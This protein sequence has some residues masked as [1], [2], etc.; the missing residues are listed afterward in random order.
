[1]SQIDGEVQIQR[2]EK[3]LFS[4]DTL[5]IQGALKNLTTKY[6]AFFPFYIQDL[7]RLAMLNDSLQ[8]EKEIKAFIYNKDIRSVYDTSQLHFKSLDWLEKDLSQ[9]FKYY[10][11]YVGK[12]ESIPQVVSVVSAFNTAAFTFGNTHLGISLDMYLGKDF[13]VYPLIKIPHYVSNRLSPEYI[14]PNAMMSWLKGRFPEPQKQTRFIDQMMYEGKLLYALDLVLPTTADTLKTGFTAQQ[15]EW[16]EENEK[17]IWS[18]IIGEKLLYETDAIK[19]SKYIN[20]APTT[21]GMPPQSP[22][23][24]ANWLG[25]R[26]VETFMENFPKTTLQELFAIEDGQEILQKSRYKPPQ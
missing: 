13:G 16:C 6:P 2:F 11:Y 21:S 5:Q 18:F 26:M 25:K 3:D 22:G 9:A 15:L 8:A 23:R 19:I 14:V 17:N 4:I 12:G 7:M 10:R 1:M 24:V 20:D